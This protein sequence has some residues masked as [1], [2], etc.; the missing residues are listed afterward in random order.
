MALSACG[1]R[2]RNLMP[3]RT[4]AESAIHSAFL[5]SVERESRFQ[6]WRLGSTNPWR[7]APGSRL[8][9]A[10][11]AL[12]TYLASS[13]EATTAISASAR[14]PVTR[15]SFCNRTRRSDLRTR[16][17]ACKT[18]QHPARDAVA[19][20]STDSLP[21]V[22]TNAPREANACRAWRAMGVR[23][24]FEGERKRQRP[25]LAL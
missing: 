23:I 8:N 16:V 11:L 2:P 25:G 6:R 7:V 18:R 10:P 19:Q 24:A 21:R 1:H 12:N 4:S 15:D 17:R 22:G 20:T 3:A 13:A 14:F 9:V 5:H